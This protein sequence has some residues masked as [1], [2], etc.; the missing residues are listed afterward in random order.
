MKLKDIHTNLE[1]KINLQ[2]Y[3]PKID[4]SVD[5]FWA[6]KN[7]LDLKNTLIKSIRITRSK[8]IKIKPFVEGK[9]IDVLKKYAL[10]NSTINFNKNIEHKK[11]FRNFEYINKY[12]WKKIF[13]IIVLILFLFLDKVLAEYFLLSWYKKIVQLKDNQVEESREELILS[14]NLDFKISNILFLPFKIFSWKKIE[15]ANNLIK[16]WIWLTNILLDWNNLIKWLDKI[17]EDKWTNNIMYSQFLLNNRKFFKIVEKKI[18]LSI[19]EFDKIKLDNF[20]KQEKVNRILR[21]LKRIKFYTNVFNNNFIES[22]NIL[23]HSKRKKYL[24]AFQNN[25][26]IR[27]Q[28]GFMWSLWIIEIFRWEI[29]KFEKRDIYDYE[30]KIK[31]SEYKK[32]LAP[33]WINKMTKYLWLRDSNYFINHQDAWYKISFF[34]QKVDI[35][36]D[37]IIYLN[38]NTLTNILDLV[39]EYESNILKSKINSS[40][41]STIMSLLVEAKVSQKSTM[42]TPKKVLF[43]FIEEFQKKIIENNISKIKIIDSIYNDIQNR[44][45][46]FYNLDKSERNLLELYNLFNPINYKETL[47][48]TYPVFNSISWN[49]SDRYMKIFFNKKIEQLNDCSYITEFKI[50]LKHTYSKIDEFKINKLMNKF[51]ITENKEKLLEIQWMWINKQYVRVIIPKDAKILN[52]KELWKNYWINFYK[53]RWKSISFYMNTWIWKQSEK[54]IKYKLLNKSCKEYSYKHYKQ[55]WIKE[56]NLNINYWINNKN[57]EHIKNDVYFE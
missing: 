18:D 23:W 6:K 45:L 16:W 37:W 11:I 30:F 12:F 50:N 8:K 54:I 29:K 55:P 40:N 48:F 3:H 13:I 17:I 44:E 53:D 35:N 46:V 33:D 9:S 52:K 25:D 36:I 24:I 15:N 57:F 27:S 20:E 5:S 43:D 42:W 38:I 39:W 26:E 4:I 2:K 49:K 7:I 22:L 1:K 41:F 10:K 51:W 21:W 34:M 19:M 47:D 14:S 56:Y 31:K 32:E 28:G